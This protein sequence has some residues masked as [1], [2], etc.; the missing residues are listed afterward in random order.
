LTKEQQKERRGASRP[1]LSQRTKLSSGE[2]LLD[3]L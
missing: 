3:A 2:A 1:A